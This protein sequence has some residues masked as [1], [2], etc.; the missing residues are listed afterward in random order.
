MNEGTSVNEWSW[1]NVIEVSAVDNTLFN[2]YVDEEMLNLHNLQ[3][4]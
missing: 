4:N 2:G 3:M 1:N